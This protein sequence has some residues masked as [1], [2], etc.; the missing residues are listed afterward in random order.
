MKNSKLYVL[1][2]PIISF[3]F[4][5]FYRPT[6]VGKENIPSDGGVVLAGNHTNNFD[7]LLLLSSTKRPIHFLAKIELFRGIKKI[8]FAN[9]GLIPVNRRT[10]NAEAL[11][12]AISYLKY[13]HVV[14]VFPEGTFNRADKTLLPFKIGAVKMASSAGVPIVPFVITGD[15]KLFS[16]N[17]QL[18]FLKPIHIREDLDQENTKLYEMIKKKVEEKNDNI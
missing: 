5:L 8:I 9:L 2:R 14:G 18:E 16:K 6:I 4:K 15:Y 3:L 7:C 10:K 17:L 1:V 13:D 12:T 11:K